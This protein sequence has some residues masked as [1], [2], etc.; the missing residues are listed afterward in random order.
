MYIHPQVSVTVGKLTSY[1]DDLKVALESLV[2]SYGDSMIP[3][4]PSALGTD[5]TSFIVPPENYTYETSCLYPVRIVGC[6]QD[7][8]EQLTAAA[9][10][11][12]L[13]ILYLY[14]D[15]L[16]E[17]VEKVVELHLPALHRFTENPDLVVF[18]AELQAEAWNL[19]NSH[20]WPTIFFYKNSKLVHEELV[21]C[22][23]ILEKK[24]PDLIFKLK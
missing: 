13:L 12:K 4:E 19:N 11:S 1:V 23:W 17:I 16:H 9:T 20:Y 21:T 10:G 14:C 22:P 18:W 15:A 8:E 7:L 5:W 24:V 2:L 6:E 3:I